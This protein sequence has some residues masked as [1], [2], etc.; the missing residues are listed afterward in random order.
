MVKDMPKGLINGKPWRQEE[1]KHQKLGNQ[2]NHDLQLGFVLVDCYPRGKRV[3]RW[4]AGLGQRRVWGCKAR[5]MQGKIQI[6]TLLD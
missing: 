1:R 4:V 3:A 6:S 2:Q 5:A